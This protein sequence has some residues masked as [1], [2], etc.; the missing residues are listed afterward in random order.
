MALRTSRMGRLLRLL[1]WLEKRIRLRETLEGLGT[2]PFFVVI[3][4]LVLFGRT[5][6]TLYARQTVD[7]CTLEGVKSNLN[8]FTHPFEVACGNLKASAQQHSRLSM[9]PSATTLAQS[10]L[11]QRL[12]LPRTNQ[13][14]PFSTWRTSVLNADDP[15][16]TTS[17]RKGQTQVVEDDRGSSVVFNTVSDAANMGFVV[18]S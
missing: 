5:G 1:E 8:A 3:S 9:L 16:Y 6:T 13:P 15:S 14:E 4:C 18:L 17:I 10:S 11:S 2:T 7:Y 12:L